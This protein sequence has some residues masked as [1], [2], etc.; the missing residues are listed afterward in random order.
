MDSPSPG[1]GEV[2]I[3]VAY[4]GV[5]FIDVMGRRGDQ[6]YATGWPWVAGAEVEGTVREIG[7]GVGELTCGQ[8]VAA[9]T[10]GGG[11]A[12]VAVANAGLVVPV[13]R[14]VP[15][16]MAAAAPL[17]MTTA[18]LLLD[19]ADFRPGDRL[20]VHSAAG[21]VG[22][23]VARLVGVL[24][25][26]L[27]IGTTGRPDET[28]AAATMKAGYDVIIPRGSGLVDAVLTAT[29]G[30]GVDAVLDPLGTSMVEADTAMLSAPGRLVLFGNAP[31]PA[32]PQT[33]LPGVG[34]LIG[35]TLT[36]SGF[37]HRGL[38]VQAPG[39]VASALRRVLDLIAAGRLDIPLTRLA[40]L[41]D[42]PEVHD[43]LADGRGSGKYV[44]R[45]APRAV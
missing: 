40:D 22:T 21:G 18:L 45:I 36:I 1:P 37:S 26:G 7:A 2:T 23:A 17:G 25:G 8:R 39:V 19:L 41:E 30:R 11:L 29:G 27:L 38:S 20:L 13:P 15:A 6:G 10:P 43:R 24:G 35:R 9:V 4:A 3:D 28:R 34:E 12:E 44:V 16:G 33:P 42:V 5:N 32:G 31:G 14:G